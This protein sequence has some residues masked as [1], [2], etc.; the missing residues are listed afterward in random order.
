M[1]TDDFAPDP[2]GD[3]EDPTKVSV[4]AVQLLTTIGPPLTVAT[5]LLFYFGWARTSIEARQLGVDDSVFGYSTQD[6]VLR[7]IDALFLPIVVTA[8]AGIIVL[9]LHGWLVAGIESDRGRYRRGVA[10][11]F[12]AIAL[13]ACLVLPATG[14]AAERA[15]PQLAGLILPL[16]IVLGLLLTD[17]SAILRRRLSARSRS[18]AE[19]RRLTVVR[20]MMAVL[21]TAALFWWVSQFAAVVG[22]GLAYQIADDVDRLT[23]VVVYSEK[24]LQLSAPGVRVTHLAGDATAYSFRYEG[25]RL[26]ERSNGRLFLLPAGWTIDSGTLVVVPDDDRVRVE[27]THGI[28]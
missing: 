18:P 28:E 19:R 25:L 14:L 12:A 27:Y 26:L 10:R 13:P 1:A 16:S 5:A 15:W 7:S 21:I 20:S 24:D 17:Y 8:A 6:Y 22:R 23:G 11:G 4:R 9:L 3:T 2:R